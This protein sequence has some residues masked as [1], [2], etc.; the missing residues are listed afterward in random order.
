MN[1]RLEMLMVAQLSVPRSVGQS[2]DGSHW[3]RY[4]GMYMYL[5]DTVRGSQTRDIG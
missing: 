3:I 4:L 2:T 1:C 5:R